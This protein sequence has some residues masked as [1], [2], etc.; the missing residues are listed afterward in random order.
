M[1][2]KGRVRAVTWRAGV[3]FIL[4]LALSWGA[5]ARLALATELIGVNQTGLG[6]MPAEQRKVIISNMQRNG[7]RVVRIP[8]HQPFEK[9]LDAIAEMS[10]HDIRVVLVISLNQKPYFAPSAPMRPGYDRV[11][12]AYPLSQIDPDR[13]RDAFG[14]VWAELERRR[15][16]LLAVQG[17]NEINWTF[18]GD[19]P[20]RRE[21]GTGAVHTDPQRQPWGAAFEQGLD[22]YIDIARTVKA[23]RD[24]SQINR[25][26]KVLAAGLARIQPSF[27]ATMGVQSVDPATT[28]H[29]LAMRGLDRIIDARAMHLYPQPS[30]SPEQ[31]QKALD[32]A[33]SDCE[34]DGP[35]K[36]CWLTEWGFNS[37]SRS[38]PDDD[39]LRK[40]LVEETRRAID[41]AA[42]RGWLV[43]ALYFEWEGKTPRSVWRCGRLSPAGRIAISSSMP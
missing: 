11:E 31:R 26:A 30:D 24:G 9:V 22:R 37:L 5:I 18:N 43:S 28:L 35:S 27:A 12:T 17:G 39:S 8:L 14:A 36:G 10:A 34:V 1:R 20:V 32:S 33:L 16:P 41:Q 23:L 13:F 3:A 7:V 19:V 42:A 15:L 4:A 6:W 21:R 2:T 29:L 38:C 40:V 25:D